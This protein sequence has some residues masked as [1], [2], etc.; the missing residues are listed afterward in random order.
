M[1]LRG[2]IPIQRHAQAILACVCT[3]CLL[4]GTALGCGR[5]P[6]EVEPTP[7][8]T[9]AAQPI[10]AVS[11]PAAATREIPPTREP[12]ATA[13]APL[14]PAV[15][16]VIDMGGPATAGRRPLS[17]AL[18]EGSV[19]VANEGT[20]NLSIVR[21]G[22]VQMAFPLQPGPYRVAASPVTGR[23]YVAA[24]AGRTIYVVESDEITDLWPTE[25]RPTALTVAEGILWVGNSDGSITQLDALSGD[26]RAV[27]APSAE[28]MIVDLVDL[29]GG[30]VLAATYQAVHLLRESDMSTVAARPYPGYR[31]AVAAGGAVYVCAYDRASGHTIVDKLDATTL[32]LLDSVTVADD[33]AGI[34]VDA[35]LERLYTCGTVTNRIEAIDLAD[36]RVVAAVTAGL[37]P[38]RVYLE[39]AT[40]I[41]Y[42]TCFQ[43]DTLIMLQGSDLQ[44]V[45]I[46][47]LALYVTALTPSASGGLYV[48]LNTGAVRLLTQDADRILYD[49]PGYPVALAEVAEGL[50]LAVLDG[51]ASQVMTLDE[52]GQLTF[53]LPVAAVSEGLHLDAKARVLYAGNAIVPLEAGSP[54]Y[55]RIVIDQLSTEP[56]RLLRDPGRDM[57][58]AV[59]DNGIPGS[60]GGRVV[61]RREGNSWSSSDVPGRLGVLELVY[62][63]TTDRFYSTHEHMG[64][65]GLQIWDANERRELLYVELDASPVA[66]LLNTSRHHLWVATTTPESP[67]EPGSTLLT[68]YD[69]RTLQPV[70]SLRVDDTVS[71]GTVDPAT[72]RLYFA[73]SSRPLIYVLQD[74]PYGSEEV[75]GTLSAPTPQATA[76]ASAT[77]T[78]TVVSLASPS[79]QPTATQRPTPT[80]SATALPSCTVPVLADLAAY[81]QQDPATFGCATQPA[82]KDNWGW[83]PFERGT[84]YWRRD[85]HQVLL[86]LPDGQLRTFEDRWQEG[87]PDQT[88]Q[89]TPPEG[90]WQ[91]IRGFGLVWCEEP[92]VRDTLGWALE[93]EEA[94][95]CTYQLF[96]NGL[97]FIAPQGDVIWIAHDGTWALLKP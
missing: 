36:G 41:L 61:Y 8:P 17:F 57:L 63:E 87:M 94:F 76:Y 27:L 24:E 33:V 97:M 20:S 71:T 29:D 90:L 49:G 62:D 70:A 85:T 37:A 84:A 91:P 32:H 54:E 60:N 7:S 73:S 5:A 81:W 80:P 51:A 38:Q 47:P 50:S 3:V 39:P 34:A 45:E 86:A 9:I 12:A 82:M 1:S 56:V 11:S 53:T 65:Y 88:C 15:Q 13:T 23:V 55:L 40:G 64:E 19:Y 44:P 74:A 48:G 42:A 30:S 95:L 96:A 83:Q 14:A 89:A 6:A 67:T 4:L 28:G 10:T 78:A 18:S 75:P 35:R 46:V 2:H 21:D 59:A 31:S 93:P 68:A 22:Q 77:A 16:E 26:R 43:S 79:P 92:G 72:D 69:T 52:D 66:L 25:S 58:Y